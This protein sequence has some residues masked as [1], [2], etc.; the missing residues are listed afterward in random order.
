MNSLV[1]DCMFSLVEARRTRKNCRWGG[2]SVSQGSGPGEI[3]SVLYAITQASGEFT[4]HLGNIMSWDLI[5]QQKNLPLAESIR[6]GWGH[7]KALLSDI[8]FRSNPCEW[9]M[10]ACWG[11]SWR[12]EMKALISTVSHDSLRYITAT[13]GHCDFIRLTE[14]AANIQCVYKDA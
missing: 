4:L 2:L 5:T 1:Y 7:E 3:W 10:A 13:F 6:W 12:D 9:I 14:A 8:R 11:R